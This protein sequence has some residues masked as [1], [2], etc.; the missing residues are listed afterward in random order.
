MIS[1]FDAN[2]LKYETRCDMIDCIT[3]DVERQGNME[4]N[5]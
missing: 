3:I 5:L 4:G 2:M 1:Y